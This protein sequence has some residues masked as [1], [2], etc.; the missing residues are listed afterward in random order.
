VLTLAD[1]FDA[2][3]AKRPYQKSKTFEEAF[4]EIRRCKGTQFDPELAEQFIKAIENSY[5]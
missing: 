4:A 1:S 3:T 5:F 2:M